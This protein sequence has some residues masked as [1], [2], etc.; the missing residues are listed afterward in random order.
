MALEELDT[1][2][3]AVLVT[4]RPG[5]RREAAHLGGDSSLVSKTFIL[6]WGEFR[7]QKVFFP[8]P[9]CRGDQKGL[10]HDASFRSVRWDESSTNLEE[11]T[12]QE[13]NT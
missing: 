13:D 2:P 5:Q 10:S 7:A 4:P 8:F 6:E 3:K 12:R 11:E 1:W 9:D